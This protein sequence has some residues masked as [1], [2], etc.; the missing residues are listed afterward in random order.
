MAV[1]N[2]TDCLLE[3][4]KPIMFAYVRKDFCKCSINKLFYCVW[5]IDM[6]TLCGPHYVFLCFLLCELMPC[7]KRIQG[8]KLSKSDY[9]WGQVP[10]TTR[11][12][13][14][15]QPMMKLARCQIPIC[16]W[17]DKTHEHWQQVMKLARC[18]ITSPATTCGANTTVA[19][20]KL[21]GVGPSVCQSACLSVCRSV[22]LA[23]LSVR[24]SVAASVCLD[25]GLTNAS[26][27]QATAGEGKPAIQYPPRSRLFLF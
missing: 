5:A 4:L 20:C 10:G 13:E 7:Q 16:P 18:K 17:D 15:F 11:P 25:D 9:C 26:G 22:S 24:P 3:I 2:S 8:S 27:P 6:L 12:H 23:C 21:L 14:H 19:H 1:F